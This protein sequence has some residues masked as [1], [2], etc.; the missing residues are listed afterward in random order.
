M[1]LKYDLQT[2][3]ITGGRSLASFKAK[4]A[5]L[6][7]HI[8][9]IKHEMRSAVEIDA[10][11]SQVTNKINMIGTL[12]QHGDRK[13]LKRLISTLVKHVDIRGDEAYLV[14]R[15]L[16]FMTNTITTGQVAPPLGIEPRSAT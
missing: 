1:R 2:G 15:P 7:D 5:D 3:I 14:M 10:A 6:A 8:D 16:P 11:T 12:W 9:L 13:T 4:F